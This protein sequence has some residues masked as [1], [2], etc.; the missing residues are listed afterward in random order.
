[1][2]MKSNKHRKIIILEGPS[3]VGKD[4]V[5]NLLLKKYPKHFSHIVST[6]TRPMR[7]NESQGNPY[8]FV[9]D[10]TFEKMYE[11]GDFF[12]RTER[13]GTKRAMSQKAFEDVLEKSM[14]PIKDCDKI[15]LA[16]LKN[17]YGD[18][19]VG[20]F[21]TAPKEEI[22]KRLK[23]R[24]ESMESLKAR[25]ENYDEHMKQAQFYDYQ[26]ENLDLDKTL[27]EILRIILN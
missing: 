16:A 9:D 12:E 27:D 14:Y 2:R 7:P 18:K 4:T 15:G 1:M 21:L 26:V 23:E 22:E 13:H 20:I 11:N 6:T 10:E 17:I 5:I 19:V 24:G 25:L 3:G 8:N